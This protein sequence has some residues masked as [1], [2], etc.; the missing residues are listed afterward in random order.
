MALDI[1]NKS[2][3]S[4]SPSQIKWCDEYLEQISEYGYRAKK[5]SSE[6][7]L[8]SKSDQETIKEI[9]DKLGIMTDGQLIELTHKYPEWAQ[10]KQRIVQGITKSE[11]INTEDLFSSIPNDPLGVPPEIIKDSKE[12][13]LGLAC[14]V[15]N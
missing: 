3:E 15:N 14:E 1:L 8:L 10:H 4:L 13:F 5:V 12:I 7:D 2:M 6:Y 11:P 9:S